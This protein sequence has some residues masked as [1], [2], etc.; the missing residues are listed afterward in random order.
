MEYSVA[1]S[2]HNLVTKCNMFVSMYIMCGFD[3]GACVWQTLA[4]CPKPNEFFLNA[5][6]RATH[7]EKKTKKRP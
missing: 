3:L 5:G 4:P 7:I 2:I 6:L 1:N